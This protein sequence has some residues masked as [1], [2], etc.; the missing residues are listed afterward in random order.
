MILKPLKKGDKVAIVSPAGKVNPE[1]LTVMSKKI[2]DWGLNVMIQPNTAGSFGSFSATDNNRFEDM[3]QAIS[4]TSIKAIFCSRGGYGSHRIIDKIDFSILKT[5]PKWLIGF[6]DITVFHLHLANLGIPSVHGAM[7][8]D[9]FDDKNQ[10][11]LNYLRQLLFGNPIKY[12]FSNIKTIKS[13]QVKA[14]IVGGNLSILISCMG[15]KS[16][17]MP[18]D[19]ILF[20]EETDEYLYRID[21][22][23]YQLYRAE[24]LTNIKGLIIG[25]MGIKPNTGNPF[26]YNLEEIIKEIT[27]KYQ[28]PIVMNFPTGH[29]QHNHPLLMGIDVE[30]SV[31]ENNCA[32]IIQ[33]AF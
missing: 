33:N 2:A 19:K 31:N 5:Q 23:L 6:S 10:K 32:S 22:M 14:P 15:T 1:K 18:K 3:Q 11:E 29:I 28:Y 21:R 26:T 12:N 20:I 8:G 4:D 13:G 9:F 16:E 17:I 27:Q 25:D 30:L 7:S 24:K